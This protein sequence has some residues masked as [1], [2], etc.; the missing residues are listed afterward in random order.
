MSEL[1]RAP[2][3]R[4]VHLYVKELLLGVEEKVSKPYVHWLSHVALMVKGQSSSFLLLTYTSMW[5]VSAQ[6][7]V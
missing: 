6:P 4:F 3:E 5:Y 7:R 2:A 1:S